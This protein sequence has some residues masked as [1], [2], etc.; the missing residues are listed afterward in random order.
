MSESYDLFCRWKHVKGIHSDNAGAIALG[1]TR[2]TVSLWKQGKNAE[3][4]YVEKMAEEIGD[5]PEMWAARVM[6]ERSAS[7]EESSAWARIARK[8]AATAT[9]L[10]VVVFPALPERA[11]A[12]TQD[13][14]AAQSRHY[15]KCHMGR[16]GL[17]D[18][19]AGLVPE[20]P[21]PCR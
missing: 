3:I 15:A 13:V 7:D 14:S 6:A 18:A 5:S 8:L 11:Q 2:S 12:A 9:L 17:V 4:H 1:V 21:C 10:A 20:R 16:V 19:P